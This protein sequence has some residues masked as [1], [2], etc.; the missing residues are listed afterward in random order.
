MAS[1]AFMKHEEFMKHVDKVHP[2][3]GMKNGKKSRIIKLTTQS[4][5]EKVFLRHKQNKKN[6]IEKREQSQKQKRRIQ[7][8]IPPS[9][10]RFQIELLKK[11]M[12]P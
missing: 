3:G 12:K 6:K 10:S 7:L 2:V 9:L 5:K 4:F 8:N 1:E 11:Q